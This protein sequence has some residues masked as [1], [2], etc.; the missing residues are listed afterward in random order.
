MATKAN[1]VLSYN[2][3]QWYLVQCST[4]PY[5]NGQFDVCLAVLCS[6]WLTVRFR[7]IVRQCNSFVCLFGIALQFR[8][9]KVFCDNSEETT[10]CNCKMGS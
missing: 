3:E 5:I 8:S 2:E 1:K 9:T 6:H 4:F 7:G 10:L